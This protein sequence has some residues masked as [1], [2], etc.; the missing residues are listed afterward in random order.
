MNHR[1]RA[2]VAGRPRRIS[3]AARACAVAVAA[4]VIATLLV[5]LVAAVLDVAIEHA[6]GA[7]SDHLLVAMP[8]P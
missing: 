1:R 4:A 3:R 5:L 6:T 7:P 2:V 8:A